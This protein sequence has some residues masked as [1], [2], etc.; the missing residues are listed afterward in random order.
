MPSTFRHQPPLR[1]IGQ[2]RFRP[3]GPQY[4][5]YEADT[6]AGLHLVYWSP[7]AMAHIPVHNQAAA[8]VVA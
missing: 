8:Q 5:A 2:I 4:Q 3:G 1:A 6:E 7:V